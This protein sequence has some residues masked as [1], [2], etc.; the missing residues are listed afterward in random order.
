MM[1]G[2]DERRL[3]HPDAAWMYASPTSTLEVGFFGFL[4]AA[5]VRGRPFLLRGDL[6]LATLGAA[7][8]TRLVDVA[9]ALPAETSAL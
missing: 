4:L 2:A 5:P 7:A 3:L 6:R 8:W 9:V 1:T